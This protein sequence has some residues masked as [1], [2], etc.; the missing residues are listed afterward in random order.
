MTDFIVVDCETTGTEDTDEVVEVAAARL[1]FIGEITEIYSS[2][3]QPTIPIPP[4]A[5][6]IHHIT[7]EM[8][9]GAPRLGS[10]LGE[11]EMGGSL[12][13]AHNVRFDRRY[14]SL[15]GDWICTYKLALQV[16]PDAPGHSNQVLRYWLG[17]EGP[18]PEAGHPH[19]A[20][21]D[22]F[23]TAR[24]FQRIM[25]T[26]RLSTDEMIAISAQPALLPCFRF[27]KHANVPISEVPRDY[28]RWIVEKS[29][30]GEDFDEDVIHT[31]RH[32]YERRS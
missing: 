21:Y 15:S 16:W 5:S 1:D 9:A 12:F 10:V 11:V 14:L 17:L 8:V 18:P 32:H 20:L 2:L 30:A 24:L 27:G 23:V 31:A 6:A 4:E 25:E 3:V 28:L 22:V 29:A 7:D 19:R 13:V 26:A